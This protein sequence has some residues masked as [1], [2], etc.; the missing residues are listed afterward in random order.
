MAGSVP[1]FPLGRRRLTMPGSFVAINA[2]ERREAQPR[3][4]RR[5]RDPD[6]AP[7]GN[8]RTRPGTGHDTGEV[9]RVA[10]ALEGDLIEARPG[11]RHDEPSRGELNLEPRGRGTHLGDRLV[12]RFDTTLERVDRARGDSAGEEREAV[13]GERG[14]DRGRDDVD[15]GAGVLLADLVA[16]GVDRSAPAIDVGDALLAKR[17]LRDRV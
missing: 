11:A 1:S 15:R 4:G 16:S 5:A 14:V 17:F 2:L 13:R 6:R 7:S 8:T 10:N 12:D 3:R 9:H